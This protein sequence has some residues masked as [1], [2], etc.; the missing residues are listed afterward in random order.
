MF[1]LLLTVCLAMVISFFCSLSEAVFYSVSWSHIEH[2]RKS[3]EKAGTLLFE[4]RSNVERPI[5]AILTLN[6]VANTVGATLAGAFAVKLFGTGILIYFSLAFTLAILVFSEVIPKTLGVMYSKHLA[7]WLAQPLWWL[8]K[9]FSPVIWILSSLIRLVGGKKAGLDA[10]EEDLRAVISMT[11]RAGVIKPSEELFIH[12]ILT[13]DTK[14]VKDVMTPRTVIFSF[15]SRWTVAQAK[16]SKAIL[17]HSRIPVFDGE[18]SDDIVGIVYRRELLEALANDQDAMELSRLMKPVQFVMETMTLDKLL[19]RFLESRV[20]LFVVLDEY[21]GLAG[22]VSLEDVIEE[23]LGSEIVDKTDQVAD[24]RELARQ[25]RSL[26]VEQASK[27][28]SSADKTG[29][30]STH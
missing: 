6:T 28:L 24:M 3:G 1:E 17:P 18:D 23:I 26:L 10:S 9:I 8:V 13:L 22:L 30:H 14:M 19:G 16:E 11:R 2:L 15:S 25:R 7:G 27:T 29:T 20:H 5:S 12:N 4:L 21:G